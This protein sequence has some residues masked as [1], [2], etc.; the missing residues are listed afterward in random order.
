M[1]WPSVPPDRT[2]I[3]L[4]FHGLGAA[5]WPA[6]DPHYS[7]DMERFTRAMELSTRLGRGTVSARDWLAGKDGVIFTFDDG[8]ESNY[9]LGFPAMVAAGAT[10]DFFV[11]PRQVGTEGF[12][13]WAQLREMA[14]AGMSIQS[15]G[16]DHRYYL[17]TLAPP[18]L[19]EELRTARLEIED[20]V[21]K[22]VTLLAPPGGRSPHGLLRAAQECGYTHV[23]SSRPGHVNG[24]QRELCRLSVTTKLSLAWLESGLRHGFN[25]RRAQL[26]YAGLGVAKRLLGDRR[27]EQVRFF[28]MGEPQQ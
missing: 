2:T 20:H 28:L 23:L 3:A 11:N 6:A 12:A 15:H 9:R 1:Y 7:L 13:T 5:T 19:R 21:G 24:H 22:P 14:D 25:L 18:R 16:L 8:H 26:T 27:Y 4:M 10:G 17:T